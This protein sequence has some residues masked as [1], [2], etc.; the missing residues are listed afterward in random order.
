MAKVVLSQKVVKRT[1][2]VYQWGKAVSIERTQNGKTS[3]ERGY[4]RKPGPIKFNDNH[5]TSGGED[6][7]TLVNHKESLLKV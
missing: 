2:T 6:L 4:D 3:H 1:G 7:I 5:A